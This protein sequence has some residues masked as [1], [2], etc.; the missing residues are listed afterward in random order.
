VSEPKAYTITWF[1]CSLTRLSTTLSLHL[2]SRVPD[3]T[4]ELEEIL[5]GW[6]EPVSLL[7]W[8]CAFESEN[9]NNK[10]EISSFVECIDNANV[11]SRWLTF[12]FS[13]YYTFFSSQLPVVFEKLF[14]AG[15]FVLPLMSL[16]P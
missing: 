3:R 11:L 13:P 4:K 6:V 1:C 2:T 5:H 14:G 9:R 7:Y 15:P 12:S 16:C 10:T 8:S